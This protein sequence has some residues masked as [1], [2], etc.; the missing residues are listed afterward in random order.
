MALERLSDFM[1][2]HPHRQTLYKA[3]ISE[4]IKA[5]LKSQLTG[6]EKVVIRAQVVYLFFEDQASAFKAKTRLKKIHAILGAINTQ[7]DR[8]P[9]L[10]KI[11]VS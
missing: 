10:V 8:P 6:L 7:K 5:S 2:F 1:E 4:K 3:Y 11:R 9:Y